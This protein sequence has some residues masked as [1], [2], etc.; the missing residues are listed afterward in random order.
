MFM[1]K[2]SIE[3]TCIYSIY[4]LDIKEKKYIFGEW[5]RENNADNLLEEFVIIIPDSGNV[6]HLSDLCDKVCPTLM[7]R[8]INHLLSTS[9]IHIHPPLN[10]FF[11][12]CV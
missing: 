5:R 11:W 10:W 2:D 1:S 3:Y 4:T 9:P 8:K 12:I 7:V 6:Q